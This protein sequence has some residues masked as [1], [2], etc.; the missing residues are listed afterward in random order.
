MLTTGSHKLTGNEHVPVAAPVLGVRRFPQT[1][2]TKRRRLEDVDL[3]IDEPVENIHCK[4][5]RDDRMRPSNGSSNGF[6]AMPPSEWTIMHAGLMHFGTYL[7]GPRGVL[8]NCQQTF[9]QNEFRNV[10]PGSLELSHVD[11]AGLANSRNTKDLVLTSKNVHYNATPRLRDLGR[12]TE[13]DTESHDFR[14]EETT[15]QVKE[16]KSNNRKVQRHKHQPSTDASLEYVIPLQGL[17]SIGTQHTGPQFGLGLRSIQDSLNRATTQSGEIPATKPILTHHGRLSE[18]GRISNSQL[19]KS[20]I[21]CE[22]DSDS[23]RT[24]DS[25]QDSLYHVQGTWG[26]DRQVPNH[27]LRMSQSS[28]AIPGS[29]VGDS[30]SV[31]HKLPSHAT[32]I[33]SRYAPH[34]KQHNDGVHQ[35]TKPIQARLTAESKPPTSS[36]LESLQGRTKTEV[37]SL[38]IAKPF[39]ASKPDTSLPSFDGS[40]STNFQD[41]VPA[42]ALVDGTPHGHN[43]LME[44]ID[45]AEQEAHVPRAVASMMS[46]SESLHFGELAK[47][48]N[49]ES[50][51]RVTAHHKANDPRTHRKTEQLFQPCSTGG[52]HTA[53]YTIQEPCLT[54]HDRILVELGSKKHD[55]ETWDD[56]NR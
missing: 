11:R 42:V 32:L 31:E 55:K 17:P 35:L 41:A 48:H 22:S 53:A 39:I 3:T 9:R 4:V 30:G 1:P 50:N 38:A 12:G 14:E 45:T 13:S 47:K 34:W 16:V 18:T 44:P 5:P 40:G 36:T 52:S 10:V 15:Q 6:M 46:I 29:D 24:A 27:V 21:S 33:A 49:T 20:A 2:P 23:F 7:P 26:A 54:D 51:R 19:G 56:I 37:L 28:E 8:D 43:V 25:N